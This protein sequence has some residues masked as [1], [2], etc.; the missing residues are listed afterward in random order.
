MD[1]SLNVAFIRK[2]FEYDTP[3]SDMVIELLS[4]QTAD[5]EQLYFLISRSLILQIAFLRR[6]SKRKDCSLKMENEYLI[7]QA[8]DALSFK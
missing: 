1:L 4:N 5:I 8:P 3:E 7:K 2:V 6:K